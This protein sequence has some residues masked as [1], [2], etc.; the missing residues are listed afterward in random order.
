METTP[1]TGSSAEQYF[2]ESCRTKL[3]KEYLPK[4]ITAV[5]MLPE[6]ELWWRAHETNNSIG[7][8]ML[9]LAGNVRQWICVHLGGQDFMREREKEFS[10]RSHIPRSELIDH[11]RS[12]VMD[13]DA[14][15]EHFPV[16]DLMRQ[17]TIQRYDVSALE[18]ILHITEHFSYHTGQII[19]IAKL[20]SGTDLKF[21]DR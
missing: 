18:A 10:E 1:Y 6:E 13:T 19:Y 16:A 9:H 11:L 14:V 4:I 2:I 12:A 17:F 3:T 21:Y 7:N 8:L 20:R 15:L 5:S